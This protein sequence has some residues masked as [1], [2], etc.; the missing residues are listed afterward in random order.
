[1]ATVKFEVKEDKNFFENQQKNEK[2]LFDLKQKEEKYKHDLEFCIKRTTKLLE[3]TKVQY[4]NKKSNLQY[5]MS[6]SSCFQGTSCLYFHIKDYIKYLMSKTEILYFTFG[7]YEG[8]IVQDIINED[9]EYCKWFSENVIGKD[10]NTLKI[11]DY[12]HKT[13]LGKPYCNRT[14]KDCYHEVLQY[15]PMK[16]IPEIDEEEILETKKCSNS[17][18]DCSYMTPWEEQMYDVLDYGDFC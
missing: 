14:K 10:L 7:K 16:W 4:S 9:K 2:F 13:L 17:I 18:E 1:M 5:F 3:D 15:V 12:L 6:N 11:L 8:R